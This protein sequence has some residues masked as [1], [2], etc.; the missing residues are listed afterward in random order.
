[1]TYTR[2]IH[3]HLSVTGLLLRAFFIA[4]R[5]C[6][7]NAALTMSALIQV[8]QLYN[9]LNYRKYALLITRL[10]YCIELYKELPLKTVRKLQVIQHARCKILT[11]PN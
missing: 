9:V 2:W 11:G 10:N 3:I 1:M 4:A 7:C 5:M 6:N 8:F